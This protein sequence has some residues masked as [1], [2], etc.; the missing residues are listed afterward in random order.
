MKSVFVAAF[1]SLVCNAHIFAQNNTVDSLINA[2]IK[3]HDQ[4]KYAEAIGIYQQSLALDSNSYL[5]RYEMVYSYFSLGKYDEAIKHSVT[6]LAGCTDDNLLK[7]T[8]VTYGSCLDNLDKY[9]EAVAA[10]MEG[11]SKYPNMHLLY[12]NLG[13]AYFKH[14]NDSGAQRCFQQTIRINPD[15]ISS[16][17]YFG[18]LMDKSN[19]RI[20]AI[21]A[22][23]RFLLLEPE[24]ERARNTLSTLIAKLGENVRQTDSNKITIFMNPKSANQNITDD[25]FHFVDLLLSMSAA[26]SLGE[27]Y[28][29][30]NEV[31]QFVFLFNSICSGLSEH[32]TKNRGFFWEYYAP[33]FI[34][35]QKRKYVE[36]FAYMIYFFNRDDA[37]IEEWVK[38]NQDK[39]NKVQAWSSSFAWGK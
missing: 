7:M 37:Y 35:M 11:I 18:A 34:D 13:V 30:K 12:F 4:G 24:G 17:L 19:N 31:E 14:G 9:D 29:Q 21:L 33:F 25:D 3:L 27:K 26:L 39:I 15:H 5:A 36:T 38:N 8:Y 22:Y 32:K 6:I 23:S 20:S 1:L 28:K 16:N 2:G 10:Y